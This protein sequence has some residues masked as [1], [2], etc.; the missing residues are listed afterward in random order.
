MKKSLALV[1][2]GI[3]W[4]AVVLPRGKILGGNCPGSTF[5]RAIVQ[6]ATFQGKTIQ[7]LI[8]FMNTLLDSLMIF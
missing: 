5:M 2:R 3:S 8:E 4:G 6:E 7:G 1:P